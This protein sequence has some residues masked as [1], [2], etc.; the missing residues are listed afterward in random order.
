[1]S[2]NLIAN[3]LM[4]VVNFNLA[5]AIIAYLQQD[6]EKCP[7]SLSEPLF[8]PFL[9]DVKVDHKTWAGLFTSIIFG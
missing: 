5:D 8:L 9:M 4:G 1:M 7:K 3:F 6:H 2:T